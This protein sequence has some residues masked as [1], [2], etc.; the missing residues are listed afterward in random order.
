M[1]LG[2]DIEV[3]E[4]FKE[5]IDNERFLELVFTKRE[6]EYCKRKK[7]PWMSFAGKFCAKEAV[8]KASD[9]KLTPKQI[10]ILNEESGKPCVYINEILNKD[11]Y[12]SIS[13]TNQHAIA[14]ATINKGEEYSASKPISTLTIQI[15]T[16]NIHKIHKENKGINPSDVIIHAICKELK[17]FPKFNSNYTNKLNTYEKIN[18]GYYINLGKDSKL[19][20]VE[21]A[22]ELSLGEFSNKIKQ[23]ALK[24]IHNELNQKIQST[25]SI[26]NLFSLNSFEVIPPIRADQSMM[27]SIASEFDSF[28]MING[29]I[30]PIKK[31][32]LTMSYDSRV[33]D[34]QR[35]LDFLNNIKKS[36]EKP[37]S[38][39]FKLLLIDANNSWISKNKQVPEQA[40]LPIGLMYLAAYLKENIKDIEIKLINTLVDINENSELIEE[41]KAYEPDLIGIRV[42]STNLN[43]FNKLVK[44]IPTNFPIVV[45]GPHINLQPL[46]TLRNPRVDF[47]VLNEGEETFLRFIS[48]F[49]KTKDFSEI[50]GLGF[51]KGSKLIVNPRRAF[52]ENL[53]KLPFPDYSLVDLE[54][55]SKFLSYGYTFRKQGIILSSRGCPFN[56]HYCFNFTGRKFRKRSAKNVFKEIK[57]LYD[58]YEI[59]DFFIVDDNFNVDRQRA[60][61]IFNLIINSE[62]KINLYFTSGLRGDLVDKEFIDLMVKA[63]TIW[64]TFGVETV[65]KRVQK[66]VNRISDNDKV[67]RAIEYCCE[68]GIMVGVFFMVGFPTETKVEAMETLNFIKSIPK[69]TMPY[70]F[71]VKFYPGT[72]LYEIGK[73]MQI[74][75]SDDKNIF[76]PYHEINTHKTDKLSEEDFRELFTYYMREIFLSRERLKNAIKTQRKYLSDEEMNGVYSSF[77]NKKIESPEKAFNLN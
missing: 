65:N 6:I 49:R 60:I 70:L 63:G 29:K 71:G 8:I 66:F 11:I 62:I 39:K 4:R 61:D 5:N 73:Q 18:L 10:E 33:S 69:I 55:Y 54:K 12:C 48:E 41:I 17:N 3:V 1:V 34:C 20:V 45:G 46:Q 16:E 9:L 68:K 25:F 51:K 23:L 74:I 42:L 24:Y 2:I 32:N 53:D 52:I 36:I 19:A 50:K 30:I 15:K 57:F 13:H 59:R 26:T 31:F 43:Y 56:C 27:I 14:I 47:I 37:I 77:F 22:N 44:D 58:V 40:V 21:N 38:N 75:D 64:V 28:E 7:D 35:A 72:K 76:K 67:K